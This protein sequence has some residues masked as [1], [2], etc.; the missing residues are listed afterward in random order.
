M[1]MSI[2][3]LRPSDAQ[4]TGNYYT[5]HTPLHQPT[6]ISLPHTV[7]SPLPAT[8]PS[9][10]FTNF[11]PTFLPLAAAAEGGGEGGGRREEWGLPPIWMGER[12]GGGDGNELLRENV[13]ERFS[14]SCSPSV[15]S[16]E[17]GDAGL[18]RAEAEELDYWQNQQQLQRLQ[19]EREQAGQGEGEDKGED[20]GEGRRLSAG[21]DAVAGERVR[22]EGSMPNAEPTWRSRRQTANLGSSPHASAWP[23]IQGSG[24][25]SLIETFPASD[26]GSAN[27]ELREEEEEEEE[28]EERREG[29]DGV[30]LPMRGERSCSMYHPYHRYTGNALLPVAITSAATAAAAPHA[31]TAPFVN[32]SG[33]QQLL[34][35]L[36]NSLV[37]HL[38]DASLRSS[39]LT[40]EQC[41]RMLLA[42]A[43]LGPPAGA[44]IGALGRRIEASLHLL[45]AYDLSDILWSLA[46][47]R[48][49]ASSCPPSSSLSSVACASTMEE[50]VISRLILKV[51]HQL[52]GFQG[53]S[54]E[55]ARCGYT[56]VMSD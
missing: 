14:A 43:L 37:I 8:T 32:R 34:Q 40:G 18:L 38:S 46:R 54:V 25:V 45:K 17:G 21:C 53:V 12:G 55:E 30:Y 36:T 56:K 1:N 49:A 47:I 16:G 51:S 31:S 3:E 41:S 23:T 20:E 5:T 19:H 11:P 4:Y 29:G 9:T 35:R 39:R 24:P 27:R 15:D 22:L 2:D 33:V 26:A 6:S 52:L 10:T 44:W 28:E 13:V 50:D 48:V 42:L 7:A